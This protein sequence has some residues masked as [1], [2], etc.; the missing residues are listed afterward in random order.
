MFL[1]VPGALLR[2]PGTHNHNRSNLTET[3]QHRAT[4][5]MDSGLADFARAPE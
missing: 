5:G 2:E 4:G 3:V 1:V